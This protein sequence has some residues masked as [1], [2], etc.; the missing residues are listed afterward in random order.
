L[1][2]AKLIGPKDSSFNGTEL[3]LVGSDGEQVGIVSYEDARKMADSESLD[4]VLVAEKA[5]P[6][7]CRIM[8][9]GKLVYEQKKKVKEQKKHHHVQKLKEIKFHVNIDT[10]DYEYKLA[11]GIDFLEKGNKLKITITF[12]GREM[13]HKDIGFELID[14]VVEALAEY[15]APDSTPK[16]LGRNLTVTFSPVKGHGK[17]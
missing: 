14:K 4:L 16:F 15:G 6:P 11:H 8:D 7:V 9:F 1:N 2:I 13:A 5:K 17:Q 3:R 12:R 10:H